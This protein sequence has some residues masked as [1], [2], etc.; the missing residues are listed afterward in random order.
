MAGPQEALARLNC[1][2]SLHWS[3]HPVEMLIPREILRQARKGAHL[4]QEV[5]E[6]QAPVLRRLQTVESLRVL[7]TDPLLEKAGPLDLAASP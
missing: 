1:F 2:W 5:S 3:V 4:D 7:C 6:V